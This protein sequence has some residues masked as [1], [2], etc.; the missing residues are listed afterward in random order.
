MWVLPLLGYL[1]V[2]VG[3]SFLTLAIASGLYYLSELVEEHTVLARRLL[4][5]LIYGVVLIQILLSVVDRFPLSLSLLSIGSHLVYASNLRRFPIVK[6][7]DPLFVLS[8]VLVGLNHW[9]WFRHFSRPL[10]TSRAGT[11]WRNPYQVD[12][13]DMP[14]FTEVAS[15][16]GLCVW[17]VPFSLFVSLSAGDNILP[18]MGSEYATGEHVSTAGFANNALSSEGKSKNKGMAKALVDGTR[19]WVRENGELMGFWKGDH[20][21]RF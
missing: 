19:D 7:S 11:N 12:V 16:F 17:L 1:G 10:P 21:K 18:S 3:F 8:C 20:S 4:T 15:Y 13:D 14:T 5:R 9:L 2:I 6:L